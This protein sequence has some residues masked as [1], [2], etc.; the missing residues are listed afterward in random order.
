MESQKK[1]EREAKALFKSVA[2]AKF[3]KKNVN[4][5]FQTLSTIPSFLLVVF[6]QHSKL[7]NME[8]H[9]SIMNLLGTDV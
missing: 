8:G 5:R 9:Y 3:R 7:D 2:K 4:S 6:N 1:F